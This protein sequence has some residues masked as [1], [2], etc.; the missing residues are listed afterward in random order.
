MK[1]ALSIILL[2]AIPAWSAQGQTTKALAAGATLPRD[3][4]ARIDNV[5]VHLLGGVTAMPASGGAGFRL[6]AMFHQLSRKETIQDV[7]ERIVGLV[8]STV[9]P[10]VDAAISPYLIGGVG[11]Y[12]TWT[13]PQP[14]GSTR[15]ISLGFNVGAGAGFR[16]LGRSVFMEARYHHVMTKGGPRF[17][18]VSLGVSF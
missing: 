11:V 18:P 7:K 14:I 3:D 5:G 2:V 10:T 16:L 12:G 13:N 15:E 17:L 8:A 1:R 4:L 6:E 9:L